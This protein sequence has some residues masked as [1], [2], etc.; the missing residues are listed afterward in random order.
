MPALL[1]LT[2]GFSSGVFLA[3]LATAHAS[4]VLFLCVLT[5]VCIVAQ[6]T[7]GRAAYFLMTLAFAA[8]ALGVV[9]MRVAHENI[10]PQFNADV[11]HRETYT[12]TVVGNPDL[13]DSTQRAVVR[14]SK[15][16]AHA[17]VLVV[18]ARY[19]TLTAGDTV[20]VTGTLM[21]PHAFTGT[22]GRVF[23]YDKY[24][25]K[26]GVML[27]MNFATIHVLQSASPYNL[28]AFL[29]RTKQTFLRGISS[30]LPEPFAS[31][32]GGIVIGGKSGLGDTLENAF[33][34]SGL[35]QIIVLSGYNVM[36][37]AEWVVLLLQSLRASRGVS[38]LFG[39]AALLL[40]VGIAGFSATAVRATLMAL[41]ALYAR[42]TGRSYAAGRALL[43]TIILMLLYSP[44]SLVYDPGFDLS[45]AATAGIIWLAPIFEN[46]FA[47]IKNAYWKNALATTL[48]AQVAVLPLLLYETGNL[49]FVS[50]PANLAVIAVMPLAMGAAALAGIGGVVFGSIFNAA[51][52]ALGAPAYLLSAYCIWVAQ[53]SA[54]LPWSAAL[55]P[56]F[57]FIVVVLAYAVLLYAIA[58]NRSA[59][60]RQF[61]LLKNASR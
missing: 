6:Y 2:L 41:I 19:P 24:L 60:T 21:Q 57:P 53:T 13:R 20:R 45:V 1:A 39:G 29:S 31:F 35:I 40:F 18:A 43:A 22:N 14:L 7:T 28:A 11:R 42:A 23:R 59:T 4:T 26:D 36:V 52:I 30:A 37:I 38:A 61:T 47:Y 16:T 27:E 17:K 51:A 54:A 15:G 50:I 8:S 58:A 12:G 10:P 56:N 34:R 25:E 55:V 49:S 46:T 48:S 9:R 5:A 33:V 44:L 32:A 3:T